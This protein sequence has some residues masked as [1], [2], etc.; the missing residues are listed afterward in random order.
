MT[1]YLRSTG[2]RKMLLV[3]AFSLAM[4]PAAASRSTYN[5]S[6]IYI[7]G[8]VLN[9]ALFHLKI[10]KSLTFGEKHPYDGAG[11]YKFDLA[12][13]KIARSSKKE[14]YRNSTYA[15]YDGQW[16]LEIWSGGIVV[17]ALNA[18]DTVNLGRVLSYAWAP[19]SNQISYVTGY[20]VDDYS[21]S[22]VSPKCKGSC[23]DP[24]VWIY[25]FA[26]RSKTKLD[27][28]GHL[29]AWPSFDGNL[30]IEKS[31]HAGNIYRYDP[32]S[33]KIEQTSYTGLNFSPNGKYYLTEKREDDGFYL[34]QREPH[35]YMEATDRRIKEIA[36]SMGLALWLPD[37]NSLLLS[38]KQS[39]I[40]FIIY[41]VSKDKMKKTIEGA[42]L[43]AG[44][45]ND[46]IL[47]MK[48]NGK[49]EVIDALAP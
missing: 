21:S 24:G 25:N 7:R 19:T 22:P 14:Y 32:R 4:F 40:K 6:S 26:T 1:R 20:Y 48:P 37:G 41:D 28:T 49:L 5:S 45:K 31:Y 16:V 11:Y 43:G 2:S 9:E 47:F 10:I 34:Y 12:Q 29:L 15:S 18:Q 38:D 17:N 44:R 33:G 39:L 23:P 13:K 35:S 27:I 8:D 36:N 30:Y 3:V 46:K 42:Y